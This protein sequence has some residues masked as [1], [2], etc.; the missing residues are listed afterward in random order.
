MTLADFLKVFDFDHGKLE[1]YTV[2]TELSMSRSYAGTY[3][4]KVAIE[5]DF[6]TRLYDVIDICASIDFAVQI[7]IR[8]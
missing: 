3:V 5:R 1:I 2:F 4:S 8:H 7:T 6:C